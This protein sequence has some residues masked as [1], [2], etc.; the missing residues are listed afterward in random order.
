M[1]PRAYL[2]SRAWSSLFAA[3]FI[4]L[5]AHVFYKLLCSVCDGF[6]VH[7]L[8]Q[9]FCMVLNYAMFLIH[10]SNVLHVTKRGES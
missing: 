8:V 7:A 9:V 1:N 5:T 3:V 10:V 4:L 2:P 6:P